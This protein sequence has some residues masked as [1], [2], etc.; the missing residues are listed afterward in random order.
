MAIII[1]RL[2]ETTI[3]VEIPRRKRKEDKA[4]FGLNKLI[5]A[6]KQSDNN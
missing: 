1:N 4:K 6:K 5:T 3:E 2:A